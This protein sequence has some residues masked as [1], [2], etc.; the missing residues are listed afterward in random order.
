MK[1]QDIWKEE[2][3]YAIILDSARYDIFESVYQDYFTG[4]LE[5]RRSNASATM[6]WMS[7]IEGKHDVDYISS[8][9]FVYSAGKSMGNLDFVPYDTRPT[10]H[11]SNIIDLWKKEWDES[12]G[13]V[14]CERVSE[15]FLNNKE[16]FKSE[17]TVIHYMQPHAP[18]IGRGKGRINNHIRSKVL[19]MI[20]SD[21]K[22]DKDTI[23]DL[24]ISNLVSNLEDLEVCMKIGCLQ[25][26]DL[27]SLFSVMRNGSRETLLRF[28]EENLRHV[29]VSIQKIVKEV[30]GKVIITSDHGE[31]YGEQGIWGHHIET[32]IPPLVEVPWLE[33]KSV[34]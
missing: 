32:H 34:N 33:V 30:D 27:R 14:P 12:R 11:F 4:K 8:V 31:A 6:E 13:T 1:D 17:R 28:H 16:E 5:K 22:T 20:N 3:D 25:N 9:P 26:L 2:W 15:N 24:N 10:D 21:K 29:M 19:E 18:F 7:K 23:I